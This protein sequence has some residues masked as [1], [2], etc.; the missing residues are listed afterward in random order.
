MINF[1][2]VSQDYFTVVFEA[3]WESEDEFVGRIVF[4]EDGWYRFYPVGSLG[5]TAHDCKVLG[6]KLVEL[7][8]GRSV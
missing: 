8:K 3:T 4:C 5:L 1:I 6:N 2:E 7:N